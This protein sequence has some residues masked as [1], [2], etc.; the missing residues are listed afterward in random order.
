[1]SIFGLYG[2]HHANSALAAGPEPVYV[3]GVM[4]VYNPYTHVFVPSTS[5]LFDETCDLIQEQRGYTYGGGSYYHH[6]SYYPSMHSFSFPGSSSSMSSSSGSFSSSNSS[7]HTG[8]VRGGIGST[9]HS[10]GASHS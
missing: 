2:R 5:P 10:M 7:S 3:N 4:G 9:G 8:S 6:W 1:M